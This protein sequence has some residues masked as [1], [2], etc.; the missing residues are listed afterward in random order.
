MLTKTDKFILSDAESLKPIRKAQFNRQLPALVVLGMSFLI[1]FLFP[2]RDLYIPALV[3]AMVAVAAYLLIGASFR[4]RIRIPLPESNCIISPIQGRVS[5]IRGNEDIH[6]INIRRIF[7]DSVE[8]RSPHDTCVLEDGVLR[9][10]IPQGTVSFRFNS[11]YIRW[12]PGAD[13]SQGNIIGFAYFRGSCTISIPKSMQILPQPKQAIE[14][15]DVLT[16]LDAGRDD[17]NG[18]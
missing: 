6:I 11:H 14:S 2:G 7:L 10:V 8:I 18:S 12:I 3:L 17:A 16:R 15:P 5:Y 4:Y 9:M 1:N 13:M